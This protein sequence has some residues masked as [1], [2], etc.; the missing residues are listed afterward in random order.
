MEGVF[1]VWEGALFLRLSGHHSSPPPFLCGK[2]ISFWSAIT[3]AMVNVFFLQKFPPSFPF[4]PFWA[5][6]PHS[7]CQPVPLL[8]PSVLLNINRPFSL[9][10][11]SPFSHFPRT[12]DFPKKRSII[13]VL[14]FLFPPPLLLREIDTILIFFVVEP[15]FFVFWRLLSFVRELPVVFPVFFVWS[16]KVLFVAVTTVLLFP[17]VFFFEAPFF[18]V[19]LNF[20]VIFGVPPLTPLLQALFRFYF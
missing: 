9:L 20:C 4:I 19:F 3:Q 2:K 14:F 8:S 1:F 15:F 7:A 5:P 13:V 17:R 16:S 12:P 6:S 10:H 11:P 18:F